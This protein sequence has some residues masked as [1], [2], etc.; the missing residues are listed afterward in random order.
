MFNIN[1]VTWRG[2]V[3]LYSV[4]KARVSGL[5]TYFCFFQ[6]EIQKIYIYQ[7]FF[8]NWE[9]YSSIMFLLFFFSCPLPPP[10][11]LPPAPPSTLVLLLLCVRQ[12][13]SQLVSLIFVRWSSFTA[14]IGGGNKLDSI[15]IQFGRQFPVIRG[16]CARPRPGANQSSKSN[17]NRLSWRW[18]ATANVTVDAA[19][20]ATAD[21]TAGANSGEA[22]SPVRNSIRGFVEW[23]TRNRWINSLWLASDESIQR[24]SK[25][26]IEIRPRNVRV[27][28]NSAA[29]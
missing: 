23:L 3:K 16:G 25:Y 5:F 21:A 26:G 10:T 24:D 22:S 15:W 4:L 1:S 29:S 17:L 9:I 11:P 2:S 18:S 12:L 13:I 6:K 19:A 14:K 8:W 28:T 7:V 27:T 20:N